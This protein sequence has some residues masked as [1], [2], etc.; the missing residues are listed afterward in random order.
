MQRISAHPLLRK[1]ESFRSFLTS[2]T[3]VYPVPVSKTLT[4]IFHLTSRALPVL[5]DL[6]KVPKPKGN[7]LSTMMAKL[8]TYAEADE[9]SRCGFTMGTCSAFHY[10][11]TLPTVV[12]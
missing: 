2:E 5:V 4:P 1:D 11:D 12:R 6:P 7:T 8:S 10:R 3:K 9:A